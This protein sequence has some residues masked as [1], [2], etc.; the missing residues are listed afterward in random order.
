MIFVRTIPLTVSS[1][2]S[3][4]S[5]VKEQL[6]LLWCFTR[7]ETFGTTQWRV[8]D[9]RTCI[10]NVSIWLSPTAQRVGA[11]VAWPLPVS[12]A[13]ESEPL[14][15]GLHRQ[16]RTAFRTLFLTLSD[17]FREKKRCWWNAAISLTRWPLWE[18]GRRQVDIWPVCYC[19]FQI[20]WLSGSVF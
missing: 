9:D 5:C 2:Y 1:P 16:S 6:R 11:D 3:L 10:F 20:S 12:D 15:T 19:E 4:S 7:E 17:S 14:A 8:N 13:S 18:E